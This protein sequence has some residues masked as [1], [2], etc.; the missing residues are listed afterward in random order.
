MGQA[1]LAQMGQ[2]YVAV[3]NLSWCR[4]RLGSV[5][6]THDLRIAIRVVTHCFHDIFSL[7]GPSVDVAAT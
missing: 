4:V 2:F 1:K 7:V 6:V 5:F 3:Y